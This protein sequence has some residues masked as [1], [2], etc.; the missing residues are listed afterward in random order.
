MLVIRRGRAEVRR[1]QPFHAG[2]VWLCLMAMTSTFDQI[3]L[4]LGTPEPNE[5][6]V[7]VCGMN[8]QAVRPPR[9][10]LLTA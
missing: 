3:R 9:S 7:S 2:S 6:W 4:V 8:V 10:L 5:L 1:S